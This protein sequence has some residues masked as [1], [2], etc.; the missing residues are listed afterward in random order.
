M[1]SQLDYQLYVQ[2]ENDF[3][4]EPYRLERSF[5]DL[6]INGDIE[7]LKDNQI[8]Y[9]GS[10]DDGKGT[11]SDNPVSNARYHM[12]INTALVSR[13]CERAG[14][15]HETA[16]TLSDLYIRRADKCSTV[17]GLHALNNEMSLEYAGLMKSLKP[18]LSPVVRRVSDYICDN[19]HKKITV[20]ELAGFAGYNRSYLSVLFK[21]ETGMTL[22]GFITH[23]RIETACNML[24]ST[25]FGI[26]EISQMLAFASQSRFCEVFRR[27]K[28]I[29]PARYRK[30]NIQ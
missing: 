4:H 17:K 3:R 9:S 24:R 5:Y 19:L 1:K 7:Q 16:Y 27:E 6:V 8:K 10:P 14:L 12:I 18:R 26:S 13:E 28:G 25:R 20:D 11:L 30:E 15:S 23:K 29:T 21:S 2:R 22:C